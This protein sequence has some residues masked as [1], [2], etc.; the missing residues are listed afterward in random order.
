M[1]PIIDSHCHVGS[2]HQVIQL[3]EKLLVKMDEL[4]VDKAVICP[5]GNHIVCRNIEGNNYIAQVANKYPDRF[6]GFASVNPWYGQ[7]SVKE[8]ERAISDLGL[9]GLKLHPSLQGFHANDRIVYPLIEFASQR[10]IP[11]YIHSGTPVMSL[12]LQILDLARRFPK[13]NFILG[14]MGGADFYVDVP[15]SFKG[16]NNVYYETSLTCHSGYVKE[17]I[18]ELGVDRVIFGSDSPTS[19]IESELL[20]IRVLALKDDD[21]EKILYKN[22]SL[23][24]GL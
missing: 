4:G 8:L 1:I 16:I 11:V 22:V 24:L 18:A 20:K 15:R 13:C 3:P 12:P 21:L 17:A 10:S 14:H 2:S 23:L 7:D 9:R 5:M 19:N 6:I